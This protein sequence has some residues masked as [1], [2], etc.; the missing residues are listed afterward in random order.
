MKGGRHQ[1]EGRFVRDRIS[2]ED[3]KGKT[4]NILGRRGGGKTTRESKAESQEKEPRK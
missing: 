2:V 3:P 4:K 1:K